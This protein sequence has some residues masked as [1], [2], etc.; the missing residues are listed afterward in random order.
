[1][2]L[3]GDAAMPGKRGGETADFASAHRVR[4]PRQAERPRA[5]LADLSSCQ[6]Q[7]DQRRILGRAARRLIEALTIER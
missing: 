3:I 4:L 1:M 6:V 5:C 2:R 7:I